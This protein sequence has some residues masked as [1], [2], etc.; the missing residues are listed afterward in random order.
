VEFVFDRAGA[1]PAVVN[2]S[3]GSQFGPHD[4]TAALD[5][6]LSDM[7]G[8]GRIIVA[9]AG[10]EGDLDI[11]AEGTIAAGEFKDFPL[12]VPSY[13]PDAGTQND[14]IWLEAWYGSSSN[15]S[16]TLTAPGGAAALGPISRGAV[17]SVDTGSGALVLDNGTSTTVSGDVEVLMNIFDFTAGNP[18]ASG[19]WNI[20]VANVGAS[21]AS[22]DLWMN[23]ATLGEDPEWSGLVATRTKMIS[24]P[25]SGDSILCVAAYT[26]KPGWSSIDGNNYS[27][28]PLPTTNDI[29]DFSSPGPLRDGRQK[30]DISAPGYG[31][32]AAL[33]TDAST[34]DVWIEKDGVHR[35]NQGTSQAAPHVTGAIA[36]LLERHPTYAYSQVWHALTATARVDGFVSSVPA[37]PGSPQA[38]PN[39]SWGYGKLDV[40]AA[41]DLVVPVRFLSLTATWEDNGPVVRWALAESEPGAVVRV[42]RSSAN[43]GPF[44]AVS[45][46]LDGSSSGSWTDPSPDAA[47]PW[48]RV[49]VTLRTGDTDLF[50]P[51]RLEAIANRVRLWQN[52]PNPFRASTVLGFTL[53]SP[54]RVKLEILDVRG[55][56]VALLEDGLRSAGRHDI[57]WDAT[58]DAGRRVPSGVYFYR[59][60][61]EGHLEVKRLVIT[62]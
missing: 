34:S 21:P 40:L 23:Q 51:V 47:E 55:R 45:G 57:T 61:T 17:N 7:S 30:P 27:Y 32:V 3:L 42:E 36:L 22:I 31:V 15:M 6:A 62:G 28:N 37:K 25:S 24:S 29:A 20:R 12:I 11:H 35:I 43:E 5:M 52:A 59:L 8:P 10:N 19:T 49:A 58:D 9:A 18:P 4:G 50:G 39:S 33:S 16:I 14:V 2:L 60:V 1:K 54:G 44:A 56:R 13:V 53:E 48:Y 38:V 41:V 26:T 46:N